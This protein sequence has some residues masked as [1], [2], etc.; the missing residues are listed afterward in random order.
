[1]WERFCEFLKLNPCFL[2]YTRIWNFLSTSS[3]VKCQEWYLCWLVSLNGKHLLLLCYNIVIILYLPYNT[4]QY[5]DKYKL[6]NNNN[7]SRSCK[8][9]MLS[10]KERPI[11]IRLDLCCPIIFIQISNILVWTARRIL[12]DFQRISRTETNLNYRD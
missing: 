5:T 3:F 8:W 11:T 2:L 9:N 10:S 1:L 7:S 4:I 6:F 12:A